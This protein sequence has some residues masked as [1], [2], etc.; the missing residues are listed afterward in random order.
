MEWLCC[1]LCS[2]EGLEAEWAGEVAEAARGR[3]N[4]SVQWTRCP[5]AGDEAS[6]PSIGEGTRA[7]LLRAGQRNDGSVDWG[8]RIRRGS[9]AR[10]RVSKSALGSAHTS[11]DGR[12]EDRQV[13][14]AMFSENVSCVQNFVNMKLVEEIW[15]YNFRIWTLIWIIT[16]FN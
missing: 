6:A 12:S 15:V 8:R 16:V 4:A 3:R 5:R 14:S 10:G 11:V 2:V 1:T 7:E 13:S 9:S